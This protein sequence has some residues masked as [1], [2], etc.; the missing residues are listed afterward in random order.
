MYLPVLVVQRTSSY[1]TCLPSGVPSSS[2]YGSV[3]RTST[4][5]TRR[6]CTRTRTRTGVRGCDSI[7]AVPG[8]V[9]EFKPQ[10][11]TTHSV[12][13]QFNSIMDAFFGGSFFT[14]SDPGRI[15]L[16]S[17]S[18]DCLSFDSWEVKLRVPTYYSVLL[19]TTPVLHPHSRALNTASSLDLVG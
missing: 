11:A 15:S 17:I 3:L 6:H 12:S 16:P 5:C 13:I 2:S 7:R 18:I 8:T 19:R 9:Q 1:S 4:I 14:L 10:K